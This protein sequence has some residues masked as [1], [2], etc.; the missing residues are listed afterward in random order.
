MSV[1]WDYMW[2]LNPAYADRTGQTARPPTPMG[3]RFTSYAEALQAAWN[4][5]WEADENAV[6]ITIVKVTTITA[7]NVLI[8]VPTDFTYTGDMPWKHGVRP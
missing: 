2:A 5:I 8:G 7:S 3:Y 6:M 4:A 1:H